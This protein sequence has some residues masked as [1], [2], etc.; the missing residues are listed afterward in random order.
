MKPFEDQYG[1]L[2]LIA[3]K[4]RGKEEDPVDR[5]EFLGKLNLALKNIKAKSLLLKGDLKK[6][7]ISKS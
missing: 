4:K 1:I 2:K 6:T 3:A 7:T 5:E